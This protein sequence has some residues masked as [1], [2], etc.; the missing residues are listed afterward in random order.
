M[1]LRSLFIVSSF[2]LA[3]ACCPAGNDQGCPD[4]PAT[5]ECV[6]S[7]DR[8]C[9]DTKWD[10]QC[11]DEAKLASCADTCQDSFMAMLYAANDASRIIANES[12]SLTASLKQFDALL[13]PQ[14]TLIQEKITQALAVDFPNAVY[15][16]MLMMADFTCDIMAVAYASLT[17]LRTNPSL[18]LKVWAAAFPS[19]LAAGLTM[20]YPTY[21]WLSSELINEVGM[22]NLKV[23]QEALVYSATKQNNFPLDGLDQWSEQADLDWASLQAKATELSPSE[24]AVPATSSLGPTPFKVGMPPL[25]AGSVLLLASTVLDWNKHYIEYQSGLMQPK[26]TEAATLWVY[27]HW[28]SLWA[29]FAQKQD[30]MAKGLLNSIQ[31]KIAL[32][33]TFNE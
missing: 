33:E 16:D 17:I 14:K 30:E 2:A 5:E 13:L 11:A 32:A 27:W 25:Q 3:T 15:Y 23:Y 21:G 7:F 6:C 20:S 4:Q 24:P 1:S 29:Y 19:H 26:K 28:E 18:T 12:E 22:Q 31:Y 10:E 9:C 8:Y